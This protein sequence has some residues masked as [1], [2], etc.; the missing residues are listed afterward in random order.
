MIEI[1]LGN[2][3]CNCNAALR[4]K[5]LLWEGMRT[6]KSWEDAR[7]TCRT[8]VSFEAAVSPTEQAV[9]AVKHSGSGP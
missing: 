2:D 8:M 4:V 7:A 6:T 5:A 1:D 3:P 9:A